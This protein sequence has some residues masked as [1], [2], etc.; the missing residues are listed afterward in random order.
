M[1]RL[2]Q[3]WCLLQEQAANA[4]VSMRIRTVSQEPLLLSQ[5]MKPKVTN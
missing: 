2:R 1:Y 5:E 3:L 4:L